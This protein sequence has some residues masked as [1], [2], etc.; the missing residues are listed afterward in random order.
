MDKSITALLE[1]ICQVYEF[2]LQDKTLARIDSTKDTLLQIAQA[3]QESAQ[4]IAGYSKT[5]SFCMALQTSYHLII[6]S[7]L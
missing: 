7:I 2:V 3:V 1:K 4:F 6:H 5:K